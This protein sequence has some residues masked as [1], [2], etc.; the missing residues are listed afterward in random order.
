LIG[1]LYDSSHGWSVPL[2]VLLVLVGFQ[3]IAGDY[4][5]R[6]RTVSAALAKA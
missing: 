6:D 1:V 3:A 4:A 2:I 5:A